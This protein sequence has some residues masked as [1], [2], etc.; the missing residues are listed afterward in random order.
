[1]EHAG[2]RVIG[3][4]ERLSFLMQY[5]RNPREVGSLVPSGTAL[6]HLMTREIDPH[7]APVLELGPG[8][9]AF[10][11]AILARGVRPADL[12]LVETNS[13]FCTLLSREFSAVRVLC[14]NAAD[15]NSRDL[16]GGRKL[17][18]VVCGVPFLLRKP[19]EATAILSAVFKAM[20]PD[21]AL[22]Q[23]TYG[24]SAPFPRDVLR[25]LDL[26]AT[27][28]GRTMLNAPPALVYRLERR[29]SAAAR[30]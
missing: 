6:S 5:F 3:A 26:T 11:R 14:M 24:F 27:R 15:I 7:H 4:R 12:T 28:V 29:A 1:M 10:T 17:G 13:E 19:D 25:V 2:D 20:A 30:R 18:A 21:A 9:G 23:V 16:F 8:T 22:Y